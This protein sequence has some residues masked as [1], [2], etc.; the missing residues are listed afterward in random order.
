MFTLP[1]H[2]LTIIPER[3]RNTQVRKFL[4]RHHALFCLVLITLI[5][6][7]LISWFGKRFNDGGDEPWGL[8]P[9]AAAAYFAFRSYQQGTFHLTR[10]AARNATG[11]VLLLLSA[12][13]TLHLPPMLRAMLALAGVGFLITCRRQSGWLMLLLLSMPII[14]S[15]E[16]Y[17]GW[18]L[19]LLVSQCSAFLLD[20]VGLTAQAKGASI[21]CNGQLVQ[22][23]PACS[24]IR[25]L[26]HGA[27]VAAWIATWHET[28]WLKTLRLVTAATALVI[29]ANIL[30]AALLTLQGIGLIPA[31]D[32]L[33]EFI[34]LICFALALLPLRYLIPKYGTRI[35]HIILKNPSTTLR[36][37]RYT[38]LGA[39]AISS[40]TLGTIK[41]WVGKVF[42]PSP[43]TLQEFTFQGTTMNVVPCTLTTEEMRFAE[44][45]PGTIAVY[46]SGNTQI[47]LREMQLATRKL[48]TSRD[49]LRAS[50]FEVYEAKEY[51]DVKGDIWLR[52][53]ASHDGQR[54][55]VHERIISLVDHTSWTDVSQWFWHALRRPLNGP[56]RAETIIHRE[57]EL[58]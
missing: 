30:R 27:L 45:F 52:Y 8:I 11:C 57:E 23:D 46:R 38:C 37:T 32:L 20:L 21:L 50:G 1:L 54:Y 2:R 3:K 49:C 9:L 4:I 13:C 14:S 51:T 12:L 17:L 43:I 19:R 48:H 55:I 18:P 34:G 35:E 15:A 22:V 5:T 24:G 40:I 42:T 39:A 28:S 33:H 44:H 16:F 7:P 6:W 58:P 53:H 10:H 31:G 56:W 41:P 47:I 36:I 29:I 26:W 25:F